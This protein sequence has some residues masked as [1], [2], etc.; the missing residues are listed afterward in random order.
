MDNDSFGL[1][2]T[3]ESENVKEKSEDEAEETVFDVKEKRK[4]EKTGD[5]IMP[6]KPDPDIKTM[7]EMY[8]YLFEV[9]LYG[10]PFK[11]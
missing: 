3:S 4:P 5:F 1:E 9:Y 11:R 8:P 6:D 7:F 2:I 10:K